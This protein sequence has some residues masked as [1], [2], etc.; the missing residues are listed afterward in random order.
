MIDRVDERGEVALLTR[1]IRIEGELEPDCPTSNGNCK[2][3]SRD[4]FGGHIKVD[5][6]HIYA[7]WMDIIH[8]LLVPITGASR[9]S[10]VLACLCKYADSLTQS[11]YVDE[12]SYQISNL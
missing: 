6:L 12:D 9:E 3:Y 5:Y 1:N 7:L 11:I 8:E 10:S 4:T 2:T